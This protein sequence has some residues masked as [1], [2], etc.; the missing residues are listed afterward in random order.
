MLRASS[1][2]KETRRQAKISLE[3]LCIQA[4]ILQ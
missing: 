1:M 3:A 4:Q 2:K